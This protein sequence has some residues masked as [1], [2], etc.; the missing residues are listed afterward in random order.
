MQQFQLPIFSK[1]SR[2]V[3]RLYSKDVKLKFQSFIEG[4]S[5]TKQIVRKTLM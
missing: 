4:D 2:N 3:A 5:L 1:H